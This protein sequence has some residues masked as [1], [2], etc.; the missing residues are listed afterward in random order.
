[1]SIELLEPGSLLWIDHSVL[2]EHDH[3]GTVQIGE[4]GLFHLSDGTRVNLLVVES[5]Q[6]DGVLLVSLEVLDISEVSSWSKPVLDDWPVDHLS[7]EPVQSVANEA[8]EAVRNGINSH[9]W[10]TESNHVSDLT[11]HIALLDNV[12]CQE[13]TLG[14]SNDVEFTVKLL[15]AGDLLT[16]LFGDSLEV[17]EHLAKRW[18]ANLNAFHRSASALLNVLVEVDHSRVD[19]S[20]SETVEHYGG[21]TLIL[22]PFGLL[23][24]LWISEMLLVERRVVNLLSNLG[25]LDKVLHEW[26][27]LVVVLNLELLDQLVLLLVVLDGVLPPSGNGALSVTGLGGIS[28]E[29]LDVLTV[30]VEKI[31]HSPSESMDRVT[32][33]IRSF[34]KPI[35]VTEWALDFRVSLHSSK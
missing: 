1:M 10:A 5:W 6:E 11:G 2:R 13:T 19:A 24:S 8:L 30:L 32:V 9:M 23:E 35:S 4:S 31:E 18:E 25:G 33:L 17:I 21:N 20:I 26:A 7:G 16:R 27:F 28:L 3:H 22:S 29:V 15:V 34:A 12:S 14:Q